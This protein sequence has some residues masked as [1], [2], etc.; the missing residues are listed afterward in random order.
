MDS[1]IVLAPEVIGNYLML[2]TEILQLSF[3]TDRS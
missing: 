2:A 3:G 1:G